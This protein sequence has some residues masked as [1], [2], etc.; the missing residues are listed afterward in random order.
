MSPL[1]HRDRRPCGWLHT[2]M[3][4]LSA[5]SLIRDHSAIRRRLTIITTE[6]VNAFIFV[7]INAFETEVVNVSYCV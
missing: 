4:Y 7:S 3:T 1:S 5:D 2:E 6:I